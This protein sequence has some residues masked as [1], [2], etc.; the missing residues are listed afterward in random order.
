LILLSPAGYH[1]KTPFL[2]DILQWIAPAMTPIMM[3]LCP[4]FYIPTRALRHIFGKLVQ[5]FQSLP[6]LRALALVRALVWLPL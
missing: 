1:E 5:D 2:F 6:A 4:G 3:R